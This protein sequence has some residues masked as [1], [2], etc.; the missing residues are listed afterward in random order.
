MEKIGSLT[1]ASVSFVGE[2]PGEDRRV[3]GRGATHRLQGQLHGVI[4]RAVTVSVENQQ[5]KALFVDLHDAGQ[6]SLASAGYP[7]V[8]SLSGWRLRQTGR[9]GDHMR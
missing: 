7:E 6:T 9:H 2:V 5:T 8:I 1:G 4:N 3:G